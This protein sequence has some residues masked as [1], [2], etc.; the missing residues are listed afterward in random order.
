[1]KS[2]RYSAEP[3]HPVRKTVIFVN[4]REVFKKRKRKKRRGNKS[5]KCGWSFKFKPKNQLEELKWI[6][7][8]FCLVVLWSP[9][10]QSGTGRPFSPQRATGSHGWLKTNTH[11]LRDSSSQCWLEVEDNVLTT[12]LAKSHTTKTSN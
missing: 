5:L 12:N 7:T 6:T 1:M 8:G 3:R 11:V 9:D 2:E 10:C 4:A